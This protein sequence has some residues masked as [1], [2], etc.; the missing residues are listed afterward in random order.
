MEIIAPPWAYNLQIEEIDGT[1]HTIQL[2]DEPGWLER[3][4]PILEKSAKSMT[5]R[6]KPDAHERGAGPIPTV[7]IHLGE[8]RQ[9]ILFSRVIGQMGNGTVESE[10]RRA[11]AI[12]Y[13]RD[14][15][16]T[17]IWIDHVSGQVMDEP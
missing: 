7:T 12:G 10:S 1:R 9:W 4:R 11:Y 5:L 17:V 15:H 16:K 13:Q 2:G 14:G 3:Y 8:D 6:P